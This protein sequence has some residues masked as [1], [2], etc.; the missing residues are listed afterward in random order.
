M[1][2]EV[3][4]LKNTIIVSIGKI[5]TQ[6]ITFFL[7]PLYTSV[8]T[9]TEYGIVDLLNTLVS[10]LLPIVTLQLEQGIFRYLISVRNDYKRQKEVI[11]TSFFLV[12]FLLFIF[13]SLFMIMSPFINN[14]YKYYLM[15]SL[16]IHV[17]STVLLQLSR[18]IGDNF[19]YATGS[20]ISGTVTVILNVVFIVGFHL[21][22]NGMILGSIFGNIVCSLYL[23]CFLKVYKYIKIEAFNKNLVIDLL[24]YS[25]PL[26]PNSVS[27][28]IVS[29]SDR[30]IISAFMSVAANG[31]YSAANK[32]SGVIAT[33]YQVFNLTWTESA[34]LYIDSDDSSAYFTKM[35]DVVVRLFGS[36]CLCV[37]MYMPFVFPYLINENFSE[38]YYQIP[39]LI[40]GSFFNILVS[41]IGSIYIAKKK[42]GEIAKT[43]IYAAIINIVINFVLIKYIGLYAAS[44]STALAY[45]IMFIHRYYDSQKYISIKLNR[46]IVIFLCVSYFISF[47]SYYI[48]VTVIN[49][50]CAFVFTVLLI[51]LNKKYFKLV[52]SMIKS[53]L[54]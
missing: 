9:T 19:R 7:L 50:I 31:I 47:V 28:W 45:F 6:L 2:K 10:F 18:G 43:S 42:T 39:I 46:E 49:M 38:A 53:K 4:L 51:L 37:I 16:I 26:V 5:C 52:Y 30:S 41:F 13:I 20:F 11:S 40:V 15:I 44:I 14:T 36:I 17:F 8:L 35:L 12:L 29:L 25:I 3:Q 34:S 48:N 54:K 32:F 27:W 22:A 33:L 1:K 23:I 21:G 24:K